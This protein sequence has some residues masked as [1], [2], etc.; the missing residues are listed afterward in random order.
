MSEI[1]GDL[2]NDLTQSSAEVDNFIQYRKRY[3]E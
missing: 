2:Q 3:P 1:L